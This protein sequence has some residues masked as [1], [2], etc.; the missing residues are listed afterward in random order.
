MVIVFFVEEFCIGIN[1]L[2]S[3]GD[4]TFNQV[5]KWPRFCS[6]QN[7]GGNLTQNE[8]R[9]SEAQIFCEK[10]IGPTSSG[11]PSLITPVIFL[12]FFLIYI[13]LK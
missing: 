7:S 10:E 4:G 9:P 13:F 1:I 3:P 11:P 5:D 2:F 8:T 12:Y 6:Y